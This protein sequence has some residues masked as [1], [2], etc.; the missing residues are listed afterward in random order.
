MIKGRMPVETAMCKLGPSSKPS[1]TVIKSAN[2]KQL[3][4]LALL[5]CP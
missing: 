3:A 2:D 5:L 1:D 4:V